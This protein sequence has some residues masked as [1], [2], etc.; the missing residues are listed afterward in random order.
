[1]INQRKVRTMARTRVFETGEGKAVLKLKDYCED[2]PFWKRLCSGALCGVLL[3]VLIGVLVLAAF[4]DWGVETLARMGTALTV[5]I[6]I[7]CML[8]FAALYS[9]VSDSVLKYIYRKKK[10][11]LCGYRAGIQRLERIK[12][13]QEQ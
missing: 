10:S 1:M 5:V 12:R 8:V 6:V 11:S 4:W 9:L 3:F 2:M 13:E 7:L